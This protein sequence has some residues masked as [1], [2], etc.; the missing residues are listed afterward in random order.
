MNGMA[1]LPDGWVFI[2]RMKDAVT[3]EVE[4][5]EL[6][7]CRNC[8]HADCFDKFTVCRKAE[9][10]LVPSDFFCADGERREEK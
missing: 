8:R 1:K 2:P 4:E 9:R 5:L 6:V 7:M 10:K 3:I